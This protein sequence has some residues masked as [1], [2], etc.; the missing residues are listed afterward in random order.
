[1]NGKIIQFSSLFEGDEEYELPANG[2]T[3][4]YTFKIHNSLDIIIYNGENN[5]INVYNYINLDNSCYEKGFNYTV[6]KNRFLYTK[7]KLG[8][9]SIYSFDLITNLSELILGNARVPYSDI[10]NEHICYIT[11][12]KLNKKSKYLTN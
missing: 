2:A 7:N 1:M 3:S 5:L 8:L 9:T 4:Y 11:Q 6:I 12:Y 10:D